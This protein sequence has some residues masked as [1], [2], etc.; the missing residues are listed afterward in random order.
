MKVKSNL[1]GNPLGT[2]ISLPLVLLAFLAIIPTVVSAQESSQAAKT[3][4][5]KTD[6][7]KAE[8]VQ[9]DSSEAAKA[10]AATAVQVRIERAR[11][12]AAAHRL[13]HAAGELES[14]RAT[15]TDEV[16]HNVT[17][18]MLMSIYLEEG[19]YARAESLLEET[20]RARAT[21]K[22]RSIRTY[23]ALAGQAVNGA[24]AHIARYRNFGI[25]VSD[26][27][28]PV[29]ALADLDRL[30]VLIERMIAQAREISQD[31][32]KAYDSLALL[33]DV[34]GIRLSLAREGEDNERWSTE[35][36]GARHGLSIS[37]KQVASVGGIPPFSS[38]DVRSPAA[39]MV[40][41]SVP[42]GEKSAPTTQQPNTPATPAEGSVESANAADS[43]TLSV[44]SLNHWATKKVVPIYP[45]LARSSS[46][47]GVVRVYVTTDTAGR[48]VDV[49][50]SE[51]PPVL[52]Q[53][54]EFAARQWR[55]QAAIVA[56]KRFGL[57]GYIEFNFTL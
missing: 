28:L 14:L 35:Y 46:I 29:E 20:F 40:T 56:D 8:A 22:D 4:G 57:S 55:F 23:F 31:D 7:A 48:V 6:A 1:V 43:N 10:Q 24:R 33:E 54:A 13:Q 30:R 27:K 42:E 3:E 5:A 15:A 32:S 51:G 26:A 44:G 53:A 2:R 47:A 41:P 38:P 37:Q 21:Q 16:V 52:R 34:L 39:G 9:T 36:A 11:A 18:V 25:N 45:Q 50:R 12:L 49:S 19:N 17:S